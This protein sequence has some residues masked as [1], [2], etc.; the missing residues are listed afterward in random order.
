MALASLVVNLSADTATFTRDIGKAAHLAS[1][2]I[3]SIGDAARTTAKMLSLLFAGSVSGAAF[4]TK[5]AI[6]SAEAMH[7][8]AQAAGV[9]VEALSALAYAG[10]FSSLTT[11]QLATSMSR[12]NRTLLEASSGS[13]QA[14]EAFVAL[15]INIKDAD[16][17][18]KSADKVIEEVAIKFAQMEDGA[19]KSALAIKLFGRAGAEM[20]PLLNQGAGGLA[21]MRF[22]AQQFGQIISTEVAAAADQLSDNI[23][24]LVKLKNSLG[25]AIMVAVMPQM[26]AFVGALL[27]AAKEGDKFKTAGENIVGVFSLIVKSGLGAA[28]VVE[29][30]GNVWGAWL[31]IM[32]RVAHLDIAGAL[33]I[34]AEVGAN[35]DA[36]AQKY[37]GLVNTL[38]TSKPLINETVDNWERMGNMGKNKAP[39]LVNKEQLNEQLVAIRGFTDQYAAAIKLSN[40]LT[41]EAEKQGTLKHVDAIQQKMFADNA[42]LETLQIGLLKQA[43]IYRQ[44]GDMA[45]ERKA[46]DDAAAAGASAEANSVIA[47]AQI[48]TFEELERQKSDVKAKEEQRRLAEG[49]AGIQLEVMTER[50][51]LAVHLAQKQEMLNAA[52][53]NNQISAEEHA[54][55][56]EE[57]ELQHQAKM[58]DLSAQGALQ[59]R[60]FQEMTLHEQAQTVVGELASMTAG[61]AQ[62]NRKLFELNKIAGIA[63]AIVNAYT[64]ISKTLATY[65]YPWNLAMAAAHAVVAF[66]QVQS[67]NKAQFGGG[68][69]GAP[70]LVGSTP[71]PPVTPVEGQQTGRAAQQTTIIH[72]QGETFG[73]EQM[74]KLIEQLNETTEDGGR[75]VVA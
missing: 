26:N 35:I 51:L 73:R 72:L 66:A 71:A 39:A 38:D 31:A 58:G 36:I 44:L 40:T 25:N 64:G 67:I 33:A 34:K 9:S 63:N 62:Q 19:G 4:L 61:V 6:N 5:Q 8:M 55:L 59:R 2:E 28:A 7:D 46:R 57:L 15:G 27:D 50:E 11:E 65:P 16:G 45:K 53:E 23:S 42:Y 13:Q 47:Q 74:R 69:A 75:I 43:D 49:I 20:V 29:I 21:E 17:N 56:I 52:F 12:L 10:S 54:R 32:M 30:V 14:N 48:A 3:E 70:S 1:R 68:G 41:S 37:A 22:E 60:K 18:L 24:K